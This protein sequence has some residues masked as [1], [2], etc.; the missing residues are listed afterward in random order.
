MTSE[1]GTRKAQAGALLDAVGPAFSRLR[2]TALLDVENPVSR[3][4]MT[5][6][7]VLALVEE[8][9]DDPD[10]E[11]TVGIVAER[12]AVDPSVASRMVSDCIKSGY[13]IRAASQL[14]GR[15]TILRLTPEGDAMLVRFRQHQREAFEHIT[16]DWA[17]HER[18]DFA[19][20]LIKYVDA[21]ADLRPPSR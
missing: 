5:R 6:T 11:I 1:S 20:L 14:D 18:L 7:L 10:Q 12:L 8:P 17:D 3:K 19:R 16:R 15:R 4:D 13:L 2:R 9:A 21:V